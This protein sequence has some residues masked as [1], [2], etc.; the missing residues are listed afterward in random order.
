VVAACSSD[1]S[2]ASAYKLLHVIP[3][4]QDGRFPGMLKLL[5]DAARG[6]ATFTQA[7]SARGASATDMPNRRRCLASR[8][9]AILELSLHG[10]DLFCGVDHRRPKLWR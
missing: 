10:E 6:R 5:I 9:Q 7:R 2:L 3:E 4:L 8:V 1:T